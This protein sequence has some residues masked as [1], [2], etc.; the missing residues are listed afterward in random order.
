MR[1]FRPQNYL[2]MPWKNGLGRTLQ[3]F[4][5]GGGDGTIP[6]DVRISIATVTQSQAFSVFPGCDRHLM[7]LDGPG[8]S[9][10]S[11]GATLDFS[12][13]FEP[14]SFSGEASWECTVSEDGNVS[15]DFGVISLRNKYA[16]TLSCI[17]PT[18]APIIQVRQPDECVF[19]YVVQGSIVVGSERLDQGMSIVLCKE[20]LT[21]LHFSE[22]SLAAL[23]RMVPKKPFEVDI[24]AKLRLPLD[25][26]DLY[27]TILSVPLWSEENNDLYIQSPKIPK[28][29]WTTIGD[30]VSRK[31]KAPVM[32]ASPDEFITLRLDGHG[33]SRL[34]KKLRSL[35]YF[36]EGF[37]PEFASI[38]QKIVVGLMTEFHGAV[39]F[40]QSDEI[41]VILPAMKSERSTHPYNGRR[42]KLE[43]LSASYATQLFTRELMALKGGVLPPEVVVLFDCRM[44]TWPDF[45]SAFE[46]IAWRA[47]DCSVNGVSTA[48]HNASAP[49]D[50]RGSSTGEKLKW[51]IANKKLPLPDHEAYGTLYLRK[52]QVVEGTNRLTGEAVESVRNTIV[53]CLGPVLRNI[54]EG[55]LVVEVDGLVSTK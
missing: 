26:T 34:V 22:D 1:V 8:F 4:T 24:S 19:L 6:Y 18:D 29:Y 11:K 23:V 9:I 27:K 42:D 3:L 25:H 35:K 53:P 17:K 36:G 33:F 37:S 46:L 5:Q 43:T 48:V 2:D 41:T 54:R 15:H 12:T 40:T 31:E 38:M 32:N 44:A 47:Y 39:G 50:V 52:K 51:L 49:K 13:P 10:A 20:S 28:F 30:Q 16:T 55:V 45:P 7:L 21:H 14:R